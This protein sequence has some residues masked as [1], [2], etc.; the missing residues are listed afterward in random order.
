MYEALNVYVGHRIREA[1][2]AINMT[3]D[4]LATLTK[5]TRTSISNIETG[6]QVLTVSNLY[7]IAAALGVDARDLLPESD[8][9]GIP[10]SENARELLKIQRQILKLQDRADQIS[11]KKISGANGTPVDESER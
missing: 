8:E 5:Y 7:K 6:K 9:V 4:E 1:R 3:Q 10:T 2:Q 11:A